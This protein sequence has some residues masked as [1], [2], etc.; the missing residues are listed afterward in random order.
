MSAPCRLRQHAHP[1]FY[2][3]TLSKTAH[4]PIQHSVLLPLAQLSRQ[5]RERG[6]N[7][8]QRLRCR[9]RAGAAPV[10]A[11]GTGGSMGVCGVWWWVGGVVLGVGEGQVNHEVVRGT[12][13]HACP[14]RTLAKQAAN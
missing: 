8:R 1:K 9:R 10:P 2:I 12:P 7:V 5:Q 4:L 6:G 13:R 11:P 3:A 14:A